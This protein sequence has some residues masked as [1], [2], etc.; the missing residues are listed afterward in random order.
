MLLIGQVKG[1]P[2]ESVRGRAARV[3][4]TSGQVI[5]GSTGEEGLRSWARDSREALAFDFIQGSDA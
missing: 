3:R 2:S 4:S 1:L 5:K